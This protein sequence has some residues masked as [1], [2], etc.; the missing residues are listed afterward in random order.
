MNYRSISS[1]NRL[2]L[3][4][5]CGLPR[6]L[7]L[8]VGVPRSGMLVANL[9]ALHLNLPMTD[10][11]GLLNSLLITFSGRSSAIDLQK[12]RKV[13]VV[14]DAL[15]TGRQLTKLKQRL[16]G[17][18]LPH[19]ILYGVAYVRP[20]AES[21]VD[22]FAEHLPDPQLF[23]WNMMHHPVL[24]GSCLDIDGVLCQDPAKADDDDGE[25]YCRFL[26][27]AAP[28]VIP[29]LPVGWLV[30]A[31][32]EKYRALTE[33]WL[34]RHG[35]QYRELVMWDLPD[36]KA[37][38]RAQSHGEYKAGV[39]RATNADLF[40]ES[41][42]TQAIEI[43]T[44]SGRQVFCMATGEMVPPAGAASAT[45]AEPGHAV[46]VAHPDLADHDNWTGRMQAAVTDFLRVVPPGATAILIDDWQWGV[47]R[48]F[49]GRRILHFIERDGQDLGA[50]TDDGMAIDEFERARA[51][52]ATHAVLGWPSFWW[53]ESY[54]GF[55]SH[56]SGRYA[57]AFENSR[58][59]AFDLRVA[60]AESL[61]TKVSPPY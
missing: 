51:A 54:P 11:E 15:S 44:L 5:Q 20:G 7:D 16:A 58:M 28:L 38:D 32:L 12:P 25:R 47:G 42:A 37:R 59:I 13:L 29:T 34:A 1:L 6:D 39:Y 56:V 60:A 50:P 21:T 33:Q 3:N 2:V 43:A 8:V 55:Y 26:Q 45:P 17:A 53:R 31:R 14:D 24:L 48:T 18:K 41:S 35:V 52:G 19:Q 30:T 10:V 22:F 9:L 23:E 49:A 61:S 4:W 46:F 36:H 27:T 40:I 57:C